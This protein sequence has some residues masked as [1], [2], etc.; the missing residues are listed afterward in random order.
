V[1]DEILADD[2]RTVLELA[3]I[4]PARAWKQATELFR[5]AGRAGD[6]A[7]ASVAARAAGLAAVH[8]T[9]LDTATRFLRDA[10]EYARRA[11]SRR[12]LG[13]ARMTLAFALTRRG[14]VNRAL[15]T[16]DAA[17][18]DLTGVEHARATAQRGA[19][20][21]Q[22]GHL[23]DALADYR[24][25]LPIL[26]RNADW[27]W[28]Q[29]VLSNR[30]VL[31]IYRSQLAAAAADLDEAEEVCRTNGLDLQLAFVY[32]NIAFLHIRK[33]DVP[34]ALH[35]L[36]VAEQAHTA[37][38]ARAGAVLVDR[39]ELLLS[40]GLV[41]EARTAAARAVEEFSRLRRRIQLPQAQLML[42]ETA[43]LDGDV[44]AALAAARAPPPAVPA[45]PPPR[46]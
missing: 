18:A 36:D 38:G 26:R 16:I 3:N 12:L 21:Q 40:V 45:H 35:W 6:H 1:G 23:D 9:N 4:N 20:R 10:V 17:L 30:G 25:A 7:A 37:L 5:R 24:A 41:A 42:A 14:D 8:L 33:G 32:D 46:Q 27:T 19:I 22:L 15:R 2:A 43:L 44:P 11:D 31:F 39:G 28:V 34:A 13:E 29:R